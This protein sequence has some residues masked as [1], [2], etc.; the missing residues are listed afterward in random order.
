MSQVMEAEEK[1]ESIGMKERYKSLDIY[2][3][4]LMVIMA[5]DHTVYYIIGSHPME[6]FGDGAPGFVFPKYDQIYIFVN[7]ILSH[8]VAPGFFFLLGLSVILYKE[9]HHKNEG[10]SN[11]KPSHLKHFLLRGLVMIIAQ[12]TLINFAWM[13]GTLNSNI[14]ASSIPSGGGGDV[15]VSMDVIATLAVCMILGYILSGLSDRW[16]LGLTLGLMVFN[17]LIFP[18]GTMLEG[19]YN[20]LLRWLFIPGQTGIFL[21]HYPILHWFPLTGIGL[22]FGRLFVKSKDKAMG[23]S[24]YLGLGLLLVF[25]ITRLLNL[26]DQHPQNSGIR[27][28]LSLTKYP[29]SVSFVLFTMGISFILLYMI[30]RFTKRFRGFDFLLVFGQNSMLFYIVHLYVYG[31]LGLIISKGQGVIHFYALWLL[32]LGI[33]F[34]MCKLYSIRRCKKRSTSL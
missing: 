9:R 12:L 4:L 10:T 22:V 6:Y 28:F 18:K 7:R 8:I 15:L 5:L 34:F 14:I 3:G 25:V 32:G 17:T 27:G 16:I 2:R 19:S 29:P 24:A 33:S 13:L 11:L 23:L 30:D 21:S 26:L 20:P 31:I 1:N